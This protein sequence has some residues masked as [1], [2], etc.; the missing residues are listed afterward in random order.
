MKNYKITK[1]LL[2]LLLTVLMVFSTVSIVANGA[3]ELR[4]V[5]EGDNHVFGASLERV[6]ATCTKDGYE[7]NVCKYCNETYEIIVPAT[8]HDLAEAV[9][10]EAP[11]HNTSRIRNGT[12]RIDCRNCDYVVFEELKIDHEFVYPDDDNYDD[13]EN[14][15]VISAPTCSSEGVVSVRCELCRKGIPHSS[16]IDKDVHTYGDVVYIIA[17]P[18]NAAN[19][20]RGI[21]VCKG[22]GDIQHT[23][24][25]HNEYHKYID[26][27]IKT[28]LSDK[29]CRVESGVLVKECEFCGKKVDEQF[30]GPGHK[31]TGNTIGVA[32]DCSSL[33]YE[34]GTCSV[35]KLEEVRNVLFTNES[36][37]DWLPDVLY[38][39]EGCTNVY[40]KRC[41]NNPAHISFETVENEHVFDESAWVDVKVTC[42]EDGYRVN[43]CLD[44]GT[45]VKEITSLKVN[46]DHDFDETKVKYAETV[47]STCTEE[48]KELVWCNVCEDYI[49]RAIPKHLSTSIV[50]SITE[51][52][53]KN[54]GSIN[55][56]CKKCSH[57]QSKSLPINDKA[58]KPGNDI[59]V[60]EAPTCCEDGKEA[61]KCDRCDK[62]DES[63]IVAIPATGKHIVSDWAV[64]DATC[65][66]DGCKIRKCDSC[67]F[68]EAVEIVAAHNYSS[69]TPAVDPSTIP[70][71]Q[72]IER[73]RFCLNCK[74]QVEREVV[75]GA[76]IPGKYYATVCECKEELGCDCEN[77]CE[78]GNCE[79]DCGCYA[80]FNCEVG[81]VAKVAC[82]VCNQIYTTELLTSSEHLL[83]YENAFPVEL[84]DEDNLYCGGMAYLCLV[85][86]MIVEKPVEHSYYIIKPSV[87]AT[88]TSYGFTAEYRCRTCDLYV[89]AIELV[90]P[91]NPPSHNYTWVD[92]NGT[93]RCTKCGAYETEIGDACSHFCHSKKTTTK[94]ITR[95]IVSF[96]KLFGLNHICECG[97]AHYHEDSVKIISK[98]INKK[99]KLEIT[100][101]CSECRGLK[102]TKTV[103]F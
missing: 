101:S 48:G 100:Y 75:Y 29:D 26:W 21:K 103:T 67:S 34:E 28:P 12:A 7:K 3:D 27:K 5:C 63:T 64:K 78:I 86:D 42:K 40:L 33:G 53:C 76:H 31:F 70:C 92:A 87:P 47:P 10:V 80:E 15:K 61:K 1:K 57:P 68:S 25:E 37:H 50:A 6:A 81:G 73:E 55:Y 69:W 18:I 8:G 51:A 71:D 35:C 14:I 2:S 65:T 93:V 36:K 9:V 54:E 79:C 96:W 32:S 83:D 99:G 66:E 97:A 39:R 59:I 82:A 16:P 77:K 45:E 74:D 72:H 22:C 98:E 85:C 43:T 84:E 94:L 89:D 44:C 52:T 88:C 90:D 56:I 58:H 60:I 49:T 91:E 95:F 23:I 46:V 102:K 19:D 38:S 41:A 20:F 11:E 24:V 62:A 13:Y 30:Y 17:T 4:A